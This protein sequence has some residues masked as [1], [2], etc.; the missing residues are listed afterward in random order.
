VPHRA[1]E[2]Q[3]TAMAGGPT[4]WIDVVA[5]AAQD[6]RLDPGDVVLKG[7][8][9]FDKTPVD[10]QL[11]LPCLVQVAQQRRSAAQDFR[12]KSKVTC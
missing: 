5:S 9:R 4:L 8:R 7:P 10:P 2:T 1:S 12:R 6:A 11:P 3:I